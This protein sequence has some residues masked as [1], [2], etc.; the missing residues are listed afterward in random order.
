M[1]AGQRDDDLRTGRDK[2]VGEFDRL[3][4]RRLDPVEAELGG[5]LLGVVDDV[6]ERG[7]ERVAVSGVE[8]RPH[9]APPVQPV[10][11][12]VGDA[13]A[14]ALACA[15]VLGQGGVL[16]KFGEQLAQ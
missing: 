13:I 9:V 10:D 1:Q 3:L 2:H 14:L 16:G 4:H 15:E 5:H 6:I 8:R 12:V 11:D 7:R